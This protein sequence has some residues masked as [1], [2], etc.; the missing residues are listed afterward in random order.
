MTTEANLEAE[1]ERLV[2]EMGEVVQGTDPD[3]Q[4]QLK[5]LA[6][7]LLD[8][9][10]IAIGTGEGTTQRAL[11]RP[12][13]PLAAGLGLCVLGVAFFFFIP[14]VVIILWNHRARRHR[15]GSHNKLDEKIAAGAYPLFT[16]ARHCRNGGLRP[17][18][19]ENSFEQQRIIGLY[20]NL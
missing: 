20:Q 17:V 6:S 5:E 9:E 8:Q 4:D 14:P 19:P 12:M 16:L 11:R 13:N 1:V 2:R 3:R 7:A 15:V 18:G 10:L